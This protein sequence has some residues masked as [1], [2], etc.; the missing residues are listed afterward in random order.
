MTVPISLPRDLEFR[1]LF[2][3]ETGTQT[4]ELVP[5]WEEFALLYDDLLAPGA[6]DA[7][8]FLPGSVGERQR[9]RFTV[10]NGWAE[11]TL[12]ERDPWRKVSLFERGAYELVS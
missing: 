6:A 8:T 9:I 3:Q 2:D 10:T 5:P 12:V 11:Y 4:I 1:A 7:I